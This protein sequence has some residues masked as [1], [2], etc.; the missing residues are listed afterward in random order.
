MV[1]NKK[2]GN[3]AKKQKKTGDLEIER[4][5]I[6]KDVTQS[7]EYAQVTKTLGNKRFE[8][9]CF[10]GKTRL[11][12]AR[13]N[14]KKKKVFVK[15]SDV[16]LV[17]LRDFEDAKC[18]ILYVYTSKEVVRLKKLGEISEAINIDNTEGKA[19]EDDIGIDF[20]GSEEEEDDED[21]RIQ[22]EK[23][24]FKDDFENNF[25]NI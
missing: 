2:G 12:H 18:D 10:D 19:D 23:Q 25:K 5:L 1:V 16:I 24:K 21:V 6:F 7:Q 11:A 17:S 8:V 14:L 9:N 20:A 3:K 13:G 15:N 22:L 4:E